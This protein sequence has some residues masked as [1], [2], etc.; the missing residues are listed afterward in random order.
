MEDLKEELKYL[1]EVN[2]TQ[3]DVIGN[4]YGTMIAAVLN[5][6]ISAMQFNTICKAYEILGGDTWEPETILH[7]GI[8]I[9]DPENI[10]PEYLKYLNKPAGNNVKERI[11]NLPI[12][13]FL[14]NQPFQE[15]VKSVN[16][17]IH[18]LDQWLIT[19]SIKSKFQCKHGL[20]NMVIQYSLY[21]RTCYVLFKNEYNHSEILDCAEKC[22]AKLENYLNKEVK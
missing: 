2:D 3:Y 1:E 13:F 11:E 20:E 8:S 18:S 12:D 19:V 9:S 6:E 5:N 16:V 17:Y 15:Y 4:L 21:S 7:K 10:K 22:A 14:V